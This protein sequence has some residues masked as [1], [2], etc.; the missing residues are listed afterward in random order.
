MWSDLPCTDP[1][2]S[3]CS[4]VVD[5]CVQCTN[6]IPSGASFSGPGEPPTSDECPWVCEGGRTLVGG[7]CPLEESN[8]GRIIGAVVGIISTVTLPLH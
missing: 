4:K 8:T 2:G 7:A 3:V 5:V 6:T 1:H